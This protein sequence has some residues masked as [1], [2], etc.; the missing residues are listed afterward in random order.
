[1]MTKLLHR[2]IAPLTAILT[3]VS[4]N[5]EAKETVAKPALWEVSDP[6]TTIY[7]FGTIHLLPAQYQWRSA[8]LDQAMAA[9]QELVV[10]TLVDQQKFMAAMAG[11]GFN[12]PNLPPL[13]DRVPPAKR[14]ALAALVHK[15]GHPPQAFDRMETW[16]AFI[17]LLSERFKEMGLKG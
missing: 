2:L 13:A 7:L 11:L 14:A 15:M 8:K 12:T 1:M 10:E 17:M 9:S 4:T 3:L 5:A 6:D 16:A